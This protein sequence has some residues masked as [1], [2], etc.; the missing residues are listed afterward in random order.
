MVTFDICEG[1]TGA[2]MFLIGAY[3]VD[4]FGAERAFQRMQDNNIT[5]TKLYMLWNDCCDRDTEMALRIMQDNPILDIIK[6]I[7]YA[8]GRGI[9]YI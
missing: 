6:H 7:N 8:N 5:G 1:N 2:L 9:K 4:M 3:D